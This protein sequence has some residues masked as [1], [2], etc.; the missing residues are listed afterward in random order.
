MFHVKHSPFF[1]NAWHGHLLA[2]ESPLNV[3][4]A[5]ISSQWHLRHRGVGMKPET[6][7]APRNTNHI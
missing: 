2:G 1:V 7:S 3:K 5:P 4:V 6:N